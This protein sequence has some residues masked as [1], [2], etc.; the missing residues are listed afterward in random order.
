[1]VPARNAPRAR[2]PMAKPTT[3]GDRMAS[4]AGVANS[5][6]AAAVQ[7]SMTRPYS[8]RSVP[9]MI[10][11]CPPKRRAYL[12]DARPR[13]ST[14]RPDGRRGEQEGD[15]TSDEQAEER[16]RVGHV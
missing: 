9:S 6:W 1:M 7:M 16:L 11:G 13:R 14:H 3:T 10:P 5:R 8:G 12:L 15:R 2:S 4:R